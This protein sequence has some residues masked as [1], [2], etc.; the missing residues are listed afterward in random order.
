[1][2]TRK[3]EK[4]QW[5]TFFDRVS[6][7]L[8]GKEAEIEIA[9]LRL[10]DQVEA[11][12]LPLLGIAYDPNDDI[13]E[14]AL[15]GLD[16]LIPKPRD[17]YVEDAPGGLVALEIVDADDVRQIVKLRDPLTLPAPSQM[18]ERVRRVPLPLRSS[19]RRQ[20]VA[21]IRHLRRGPGRDC[22]RNG[23][24][25]RGASV[26]A[27][28]HRRYSVHAGGKLRHAAAHRRQEG[29]REHRSDARRRVAPG[30]QRRHRRDGAEA[31]AARW[32]YSAPGEC[33][34]PRDQRLPLPDAA[35]RPD[36]G[37]PADHADVE[38]S[39]VAC[40]PVRQPREV[41]RRPC[42]TRQNEARG[43]ELRLPGH[44]L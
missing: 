19:T 16:H 33:R 18:N 17:I 32:P 37:F 20:H 38:L 29:H 24:G 6:T 10:G 1:M 27:A 13:V 44:R 42:R 43:L 14:V 41:G 2:T 30:R 40:G 15:E 8:E 7:T 36:Q 3:L 4:K 35:L 28:D 26:V 11:E 31:G 34:H 12:W 21:S 23:G 25:C 9:S 5:R 22:D 39:P